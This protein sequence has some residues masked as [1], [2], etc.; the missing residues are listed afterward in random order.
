MARG[1]KDI[2]D[3]LRRGQQYE[4]GCTLLI[5]AGCSKTAK[6]PLAGEIVDHI[7]NSGL[8]DRVYE[9]ALER[10]KHERPDAVVPTYGHC[11]E[12]MDRGD[13]RDLIRGYIRNARM[14]WAHAGIAALVKHGY[15]DRILTTNFDPLIARACAI[16]N[17]I[18][19]VYDLTM[20]TMR[21]FDDLPDKAIFHLHGQQNGFS[22]LN[23]PSELASHK[24]NIRPLIERVRETRTWIV[25]GYSGQN[26]PLFELIEDCGGYEHGLYWIGREPTAPYHLESL[27]GPNA[28]KGGHYVPFEGADE[29]FLRLCGE[30]GI[31][32]FT[33]MQ[34]PL[35][36]VEE[37][38]EQF[39]DF[40]SAATD[41]GLDLLKTAKNSIGKYKQLIVDTSAQEAADQRIAE[42]V[43]TQGLEA[44]QSLLSADS[45]TTGRLSPE[46][47]ALLALMEGIELYDRA[48][49]TRETTEANELY[50]TA[51][52]K[53]AT[54]HAI[55]PNSPNTLNN[56]GAALA[57]QARC[58]PDEEAHRL[59]AEAR[60][61]YVAAL[62]IKPDKNETYNNW[63]NL[64]GAQALRSSDEEAER[65]WAEAGE[66]YA[67]ALAIKPDSHDVLYNWGIQLAAQAK[68]SGDNARER[69]LAA[70]EKYAAALA[71]KPDAY[72]TFNNWGVA[73]DALALLSQGDDARR[74]WAA[75]D[76]KYTAALAIQ[77]QSHEAL[78]NWGVSLKAQAERSSDAEA[79]RL[80]MEAEEKFAA[81]LAI[82][83]DNYETLSN[84]G[85]ALNVRAQRSTDADAH[86]LWAEAH[87]K[88]AAA[89]A[90]QP[91]D[92]DTL[93]NWGVALAA[94]AQRSADDQAHRLWGEAGEKYAAA[95]AI[96][97][98]LHKT[99][100][101]WGVTLN[102]RA[103]RSQD[104][105]AH[106]L[107]ALAGEK[108]AG[109]LALKPN[110][111]EALNYWGGALVEQAQR[112]QDAQAQTLLTLAGEKY[113]AALAIKPDHH[114]VLYN[115]GAAL[116]AQAHRK[117]GT[118]RDRLLGE[119]YEKCLRAERI[120]PDSGA[121]NLACIHAM[122]HEPQA[123]IDWLERSHAA[124]KLPA[125]MHI[126]ADKDLDGI[127]DTPEF[128]R[129][130]QTMS[131]AD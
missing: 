56:W 119:A 61:K 13:Q 45:E 15:V 100:W 102:A 106:A 25:C 65:L 40:P 83:P 131:W 19:A 90:I 62:A 68:R 120:S 71:I 26:D 24:K 109:A 92:P 63:G 86:S 37:I 111:F 60:E 41:Q 8:Y 97:P 30:L 52:L 124:G 20:S 31:A 27:L 4:R 105:Q 28:G 51:C 53:Y 89:Q 76:E 128:Q 47:R 11:M 1:L 75:A 7:R 21:R 46:T 64:L 118:E 34:R 12:E 3:A 18:P 88:Y 36:H 104:E 14:N 32:D 57:A 6:I 129:W 85:A 117:T 5:G 22:L 81:A 130:L 82:K 42:V 96:K 48:V 77:P 38:L 67:A 107:L 126:E 79:K 80:L 35:D 108:Y 103:R 125:R 2:V 23:S 59:W 114:E 43:S 29:F 33:F 70:C 73:L 17:E 54:A 94:Q 116:I 112:S 91:K 95:L 113:A 84:W 127:R 74:L 69:W 121:Y 58:S 122:R 98:S 16:F 115:W 99:L 49:K 10:A 72:L 101:N 93:N 87:E 110:M 123:A 66:K 44:A 78:N 55:M 50:R 9:L 39:V